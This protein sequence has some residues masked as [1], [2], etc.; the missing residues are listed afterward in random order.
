MNP[1]IFELNNSV[2]NPPKNWKE[3]G[4][5]CDFT[6]GE[7]KGQQITISDWEFVRE[8]IDT[9]NTWISNGFIF[10]GLPLRISQY[11][12]N[13][14]KVTFFDGYIDLTE[15][16]NFD[17]YGIKAKSK[18]KYSIDW[19]NDRASGFSFEYLASINKLKSTDYV[20]IP[21][22]VSSIP[23]Y[24]KMA[25]ALVTLA[26]VTD[27][28]A[29]LTK[30]L[31]AS[32]T[33]IATDPISYGQILILIGHIAKY[34][35]LL[36]TMF[37]LIKQIFSLLVQKVK[38]HKG[39]RLRRLFEVGCN[40]L[41]VK[42]D[43]S[44]ITNDLVILPK[45]YVI[46]KGIQ[47]HQLTGLIGATYPNQYPQYGYPQ[48][49]FAE[50][51]NNQKLLFNGKVI[52]DFDNSGNPIMRFER[53]D[54]SYKQ[55]SYKMPDLM[56]TS[57]KLNTNEFISNLFVTYQSDTTEENTITQYGGTSY[58]VTVTPKTYQNKDFLLMRGLNTISI[59]YA[60]GKRKTELTPIEKIFDTAGETIDAI[61]QPAVNAVNAAI[62]GINKIMKKITDFISFIGGIV[63]LDNFEKPEIPTINYTPLGTLLDTRIGM[64]SL[65]KDWFMTDKILSIENDGHLKSQ[66]PTAKWIYDNFYFV[67]MDDNQFKLK[68][69]STVPFTLEDYQKVKNNPNAYDVN[70]NVIKLE[71]VKFNIWNETAEINTKQPYI[72]TNNLN[73]AKLEPSGE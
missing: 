23:D 68:Q 17:E 52:M 22:V 60:L 1:P 37:L 7:F 12:A 8:N 4:I 36:V 27:T 35:A 73:Y 28:F 59:P 42:F 2:V 66:Q 53:I 55:P 24:E 39:I 5:Q 6:D 57:Y 32:I 38:Y 49:S 9:I 44:I 65:S 40:Y 45:K 29:S 47:E 61:V 34:V 51:I 15:D 48:G 64:L 50:F 56:N 26:Y 62:S 16:C 13:G 41:G 31:V 33:A 21:Y 20:S 25:I 63:G 14:K 18:E 30:D 70:G 71:S 11:D 43:S 19:I 46:P 72:Y 54:K 58:Q 69:F 10:E 3:L 67:N